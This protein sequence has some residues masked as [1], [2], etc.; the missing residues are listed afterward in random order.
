MRAELADEYVAPK[1]PIRRTLLCWDATGEVVSRRDASSPKK[2]NG[3][4]TFVF[5]LPVASCLIPAFIESLYPLE[6]A[7][8]V[9]SLD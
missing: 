5:L 6:T 1:N 2:T 9:E 7:L 8:T 3:L 4:K